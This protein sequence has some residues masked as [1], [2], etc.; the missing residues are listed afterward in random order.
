MRESVKDKNVKELARLEKVLEKQIEIALAAKAMS[1]TLGVQAA[2]PDMD[3]ITNL[4][5]GDDM[6]GLGRV[7]IDL[8]AQVS[9]Q[10]D[11]IE[12]FPN[13]KLY[14]PRKPATVQILGE[15][16]MNS[17]H[18]FNGDLSL[19]DYLTLAGGTTQFADNSAIYVIR[20][21]GRVVKPG[22]WFS[23]TDSDIQAG[24]TIVVP[25]DVNLRDGL[26]LW[27]QV[28]QI[29]YNSAVAVAAIRGL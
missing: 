12:V 19:S 17:A 8:T 14:V 7:A 6:D 13:D 23:Y 16:Q 21:D 29:I 5:K 10:N 3:K 18:V 24:D 11:P 1:A 2:S 25:L 26:G 28:T 15:V 22:N 20:A 9:G 27:Q 4:I